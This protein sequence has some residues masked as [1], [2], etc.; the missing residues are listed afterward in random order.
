MF[1]EDSYAPRLSFSDDYSG[2]HVVTKPLDAVLRGMLASEH[3]ELRA[4]C[5]SCSTCTGSR[6]WR[7]IYIP[8]HPVND[9]GQGAERTSRPNSIRITGEPMDIEWESG[10][11]ILWE[12]DQRIGYLDW[13][14]FPRPEGDDA[15]RIA[16]LVIEQEERRGKGYGRMLLEGF[17]EAAQRQG[18]TRIGLMLVKEEAFGFWQ[19]MGYEWSEGERRGFWKTFRKKRL[20][21]RFRTFT[22]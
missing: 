7:S 14:T 10:R 15:I 17:E 6:P 11:F 20:Q 18:F 4:S 21:S 5:S 3:H 16:D 22:C 8:S 12:G 9:S 13:M 1:D 2:T 19:R